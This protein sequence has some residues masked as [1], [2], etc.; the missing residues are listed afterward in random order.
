MTESAILARLD[1]LTQAVIALAQ[2]HG[3][4]LSHAELA[5]RLG[6]HRTTIT[7]WVQTDRDFPR[8]DKT[9]KWLLADVVAWELKNGGQTK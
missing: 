9:G 2:T 7:R 8:P 1:A 4:R 3:V 5:E 6:V